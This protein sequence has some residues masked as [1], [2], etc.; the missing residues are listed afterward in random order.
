MAASQKRDQTQASF[1]VLHKL[2]ATE[3][4]DRL[5]GQIFVFFVVVT[6]AFFV[7]ILGQYTPM[8][9]FLTPLRNN[10]KKVEQGYGNLKS[11][12]M[13]LQVC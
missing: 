13:I 5:G 2:R 11:E 9:F 8:Y 3:T 12:H 1:K 4:Y 10:E 7:A 6:Y